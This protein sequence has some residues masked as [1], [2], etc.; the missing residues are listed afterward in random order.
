MCKSCS[1]HK[2]VSTTTNMYN[3]IRLFWTINIKH[4]YRYLYCGESTDPIW[5]TYLLI[6]LIIHVYCSNFDNTLTR[7]HSDISNCTG[8]SITPKVYVI[9]ST[10][11]YK[12][13][14]GVN[15][16]LH[17]GNLFARSTPFPLDVL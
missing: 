3:G 5:G 12:L 7:K 9:V 16:L 11:Y 4:M 15:C 1:H 2:K 10:A 17:P 14:S 8:C 13:G 6:H